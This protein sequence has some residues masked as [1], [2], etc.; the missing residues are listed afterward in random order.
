MTWLSSHTIKLDSTITYSDL[1]NLKNVTAGQ[2]DTDQIKIKNE[3]T[4][5]LKDGKL[6]RHQTITF[7]RSNTTNLERLANKFENLKARILGNKFLF[8]KPEL[9]ENIFNQ[10]SISVRKLNKFI[11]SKME[12]AQSAHTHFSK[13]EIAGKLNKI[14]LNES[15]TDGIE[16]EKNLRLH[17]MENT[18]IGF[19]KNKIES[20]TAEFKTIVIRL[21]KNNYYNNDDKK[22]ESKN[23]ASLNKYFDTL[24]DDLKNELI[25]LHPHLL[26]RNIIGKTISVTNSEINTRGTSEPNKEI[27]NDRTKLKELHTNYLKSLSVS[28]LNTKENGS[29]ENQAL[30]FSNKIIDFLYDDKIIDEPS[31]EKL[32]SYKIKMPS[33]LQEKISEKFTSLVKNNE[34]IPI[35]TQILMLTF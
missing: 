6:E 32:I 15:V 16:I 1:N 11:N 8:H 10:S 4:P 29:I 7:L 31:I 12:V 17:L 2:K 34:G 24:P 22:L 5:S 13:D 30:N 9:T 27:L 26:T 23:F 14:N 33:E 3:I 35:D 21:L 18:S 25:T 28:E 20:T 19:P